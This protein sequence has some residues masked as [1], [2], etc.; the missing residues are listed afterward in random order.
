M[1]QIVYNVQLQPKHSKLLVL[2]AETETI[3]EQT[4]NLLQ[5][6]PRHPLAR[7]TILEVFLEL[8]TLCAA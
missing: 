4:I 6:S 7:T 8:L 2:F 1:L 3:L 5:L